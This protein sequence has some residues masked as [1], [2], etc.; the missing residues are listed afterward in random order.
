MAR[1]DAKPAM[2][3]TSNAIRRMR[4]SPAGARKSQPAGAESMP[5]FPVITAANHFEAGFFSCFGFLFFL[6]FF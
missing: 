1:T 5:P 2:A 4:K 3:R 6:S